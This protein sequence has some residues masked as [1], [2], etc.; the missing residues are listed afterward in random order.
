MKRFE[1]EQKTMDD[2]ENL[3]FIVP[4]STVFEMMFSDALFA[5]TN[6]S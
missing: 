2:G 1:K 3:R 4:A 5:L 6:N